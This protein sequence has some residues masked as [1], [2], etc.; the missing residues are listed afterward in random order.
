VNELKEGFS[1]RIEI[2]LDCGNT[3]FTAA[4]QVAVKYELERFFNAK[5]MLCTDIKMYG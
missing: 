1:A 2:E 3:A 5:G 4:E